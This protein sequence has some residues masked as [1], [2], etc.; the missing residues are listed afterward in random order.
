MTRHLATLGAAGL[1]ATT[2][3]A[4]PAQANGCNGVVNIFVWGCAP[5]DNN[6][7][8]KFPYFRKKTVS[9]FAPAGS[10]IITDKG[11]TMID[12]AGTK[13]PLADARVIAPGGANVVASGGANVIAPGG[14]NI[15]VIVQN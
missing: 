15:Q 9:K 10:R 11:A 2:M 6:N 1:L 13:Y 3:L 4:A 12:I 14:A 7:G 5:W 8:E